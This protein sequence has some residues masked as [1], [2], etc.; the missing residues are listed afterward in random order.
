MSNYVSLVKEK[1]R[2]AGG[3]VPMSRA[4]SETEFCIDDTMIS[5]DDFFA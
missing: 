2:F 1:L 3:K 4:S 5:D